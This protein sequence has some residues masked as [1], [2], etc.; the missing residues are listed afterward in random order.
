MSDALLDAPP[1]TEQESNPWLEAWV[2]VLLLLGAN[3]ARTLSFTQRKRARDLL[4][5]R[6]EDAALRVAQRVTAGQLNVDAWQAAVNDELGIYTR[7]MAVAGAGTLPNTEVRAV[8]E[9]EIERQMPFLASFAAA[10][11]AGGLSVAAIAARTK[12]YGKSPWGV[13]F[14]AQG[15]TAPDYTVHRWVSRDDN[16]VCSRCAPLHGRYFLPTEGPWPGWACLGICRC[17]RIQVVDREQW[18]RLTGRR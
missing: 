3:A 4:R 17:E 15:S 6:F 18:Q 10:V 13:Y 14:V 8:A 16:R 2:I 9:T 11:A 12:Y 1:V 5:V 7:A